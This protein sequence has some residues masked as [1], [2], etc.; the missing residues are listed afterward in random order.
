MSQL[1]R[2]GAEVPAEVRE[3]APPLRPESVSIRAFAWAQL[4]AF[5]SLVISASGVLELVEKL[6]A[7]PRAGPVPPPVP[8]APVPLVQVQEAAPLPVSL[9]VQLPLDEVTAL[10]VAGA[11][12]KPQ[13]RITVAVAELDVPPVPGPGNVGKVR[14]SALATGRMRTMH[15]AM[16][17]SF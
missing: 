4:P 17:R 13:V 15:T 7:A 1:N 2:I 14:A 6:K 9:Q 16:R 5:C 11:A 3:Q 8:V 10:P 12:A